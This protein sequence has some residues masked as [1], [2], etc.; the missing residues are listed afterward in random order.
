MEIWDF[1]EVPQDELVLNHPIL[2]LLCYLRR[3]IRCEEEPPGF[4][5]VYLPP[6]IDSCIQLVGKGNEAEELRSVAIH[7]TETALTCLNVHHTFVRLH[8][9]LREFL[10]MRAGVHGTCER[11]CEFLCS[12]QE[13]ISL[14]TRDVDR[15]RNEIPG[16]GRRR[17]FLRR[18]TPCTLLSRRRRG[19]ERGLR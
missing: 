10:E 5:D 15:L 8:E 16:I 1:E 14:R 7:H 18:G 9:R 17:F 2:Q 6:G 13:S 19:E 4:A 11:P 3:M 12:E